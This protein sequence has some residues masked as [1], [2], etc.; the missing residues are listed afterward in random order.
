MNLG[1]TWCLGLNVSGAGRAPEVHPWVRDV[2]C[3]GEVHGVNII[4][5]QTPHLCTGIDPVH[6]AIAR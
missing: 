2:G 5:H 6:V 3:P 4:V 1:L